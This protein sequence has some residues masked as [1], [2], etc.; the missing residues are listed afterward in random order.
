V[1]AD[2]SKRSGELLT[3]SHIGCRL[4]L[5]I[6]G[7]KRGANASRHQAT[8]G[9]SRPWFAQLDPPSGLIQP[10]GATRRMRLKRRRSAGGGIGGGGLAGMGKT[11]LA[12]QARQAGRLAELVG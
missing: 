4:A 10:C 8:L 6:R 1:A 5:S 11:T 2:I 12:V 9:D 7:A 3:G